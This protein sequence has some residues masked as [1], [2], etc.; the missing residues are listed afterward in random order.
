MIMLL[1]Y[2]LY[3]HEIIMAL[4]LKDQ[5]KDPKK[6]PIIHINRLN[7]DNRRENLMYD[8]PG[9]DIGK[10]LRKKIRLINL[11]KN[12]KID[13]DDIPTYVW[14]MKPDS[15]HGERFLIEI[16]DVS[17]KTT[18]SVNYSLRYKLEEAKK[19]LRELQLIRPDLF[20]EYSMNGE[21]NY[22]GK[23]LLDSFYVII[24]SGGYNLSRLKNDKLTQKYLKED[25]SDLTESEIA[26][27]KA[28]SIYDM[29][30]KK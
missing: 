4:K 22:D 17:W 16:G 14:Y 21:F 24:Q 26:D 29:F 25:L 10:N 7:I 27:L 2:I 30:T 9:K 12:S 11:P 3:L 23:K 13:P 8:V 15:S 18:S 19:F 1:N 5:N 6:L 20:D 28:F